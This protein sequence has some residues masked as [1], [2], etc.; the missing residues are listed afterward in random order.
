MNALC[1]I[2]YEGASLQDFLATLRRAGVGLVLDVREAPISRRPEF[3]KKA[4]AGALAEVGIDYRH[5]GALGA[6]KPLRDRIKQGQCTSEEFFAGYAEH[7]AGERQQVL[8]DQLPGER[9][10]HI[11]LLCYER[12]VRECHRREVA[13][14][15]EARTGLAA[16][17]LIPDPDNG[18]LGLEL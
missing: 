10:G 11:A 8:L 2:G 6:P 16:R 14:A 12:D 4:L 18:Q 7:L 9:A 5:E 13:K 15:L 17:H 1:T 3:A